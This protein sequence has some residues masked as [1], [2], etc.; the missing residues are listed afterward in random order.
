[1]ARQRDYD[2]LARL[3]K[4]KH[5]LERKAKELDEQIKKKTQQIL[6]NN[7]SESVTTRYGILK[8]Q[9]QNTYLIPDNEEL[10]DKANISQKVFNKIAKVNVGDLKKLFTEEVFNQLLIG[11]IIQV[12][13]T[14]EYYKLSEFPK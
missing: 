8:Y 2:S 6:A 7:P 9:K 3:R 14:S 13:S 5:E 11:Q 10:M 1:M 12:K 4:R